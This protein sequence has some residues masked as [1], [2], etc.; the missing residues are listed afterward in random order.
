[1]TIT[2]KLLINENPLMVLPSLAAHIGLNEAI[3]LQQIHY[4]ISNPAL[5]CEH[6]G[7]KWVYNTVADWK[8]QLP[9]FSERTCKRV[10]ASLREMGLVEAEN[11][12]RNT[13]DRTL[14]YTINYEA[15]QQ[16]EDEIA[17]IDS[18]N[19]EPSDSANLAPSTSGQIGTLSTE[20]TAET[21][22]EITSAD[23]ADVRVNGHDEYTDEFEAVWNLYPKKQGK[24]DA[25]KA[26]RSLKP[27]K[28]LV[29]SIVDSIAW[30]RQHGYLS[31]KEV[32]FMPHFATW[33]RG[34]RWEDER[35]AEKNN[36]RHAAAN[37]D[38]CPKC[39]DSMND[40][41]CWAETINEGPF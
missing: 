14:Y 3:V 20:T 30:Q 25:F 1:M 27:G 19:V 28:A 4:W 24:R 34:H 35:V 2:S 10:L 8:R 12:N 38:A 18:A 11:L 17:S 23:S 31:G 33:V 36:A 13:F 21:T 41:I 9:F 5:K 39:G 7:R 15:L 37:R 16:I 32:R 22:K 40:C 6:G 26:W 29:Q